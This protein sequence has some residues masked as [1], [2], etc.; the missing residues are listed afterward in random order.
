MKDLRT[1]DIADLA[2][3][4]PNTVRFYERIGLISPVPRDANGYRRFTPEHVRQVMVCRHIYSHGWLGK[5]A[6]AISNR[7]ISALVAGSLDEARS[8]A[9]RY[10]EH[11]QFERELAKETAQI[12]ARWSK[13]QPSPNEGPKL[14][15]AQAA[16]LIGVT[17]EVL[18][19]WERNGLI[20]VPRYGPNRARIYGP[21]EIE[22]L[23]II[24]LLRQAGF[25]I[26]SIHSSL[27]AYDRGDSESVLKSLNVPL[28]DPD[29]AWIY[30]GDRWI[31]ALEGG[32][33][34]ALQ[35]LDLLRKE[36]RKTLQFFTTP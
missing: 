9:S 11:L 30:V 7:L 26:V 1:Q 16:D 6:R 8:Q 35:I 15:H 10:L 27:Q 4:H 28:P 34:G 2:G 36:R 14:N 31:D 13:R 17:E 25:S 12:L 29:A 5:K 24:Y 22:R 3:I 21:A 19:N 18:R 23:R 33:R 20:K 32:I